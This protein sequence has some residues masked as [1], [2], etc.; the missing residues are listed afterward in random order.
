MIRSMLARACMCRSQGLQ[1]QHS[2]AAAK[3][4]TELPATRTALHHAAARLQAATGRRDALA[5]TMQTLSIGLGCLAAARL[6]RGPAAPAHRMLHACFRVRQP[7]G[8]D[9]SLLQA[10]DVIM[11]DWLHA[12]SILQ[13]FNICQRM[14]YSSNKPGCKPL[15]AHVLLR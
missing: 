4:Q 3:A 2:A 5:S 7:G 6:G 12:V 9:R 14:S 15:L 8:F 11:G 10:L 13:C 1:R